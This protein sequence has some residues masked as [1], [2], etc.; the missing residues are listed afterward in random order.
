LEKQHYGDN[1]RIAKYLASQNIGSRREIEKFIQQKRIKVNGT[2]INSPITFVSDQDNI[3][4][5]NRLVEPQDKI[6]ILKFHKPIKYITSHKRQNNK[7]IIF[8]IIDSKYRNYKTAGRLDYFSEG[9]LILS[10]DGEVSRNLELPKNKFKRVYEVTISGLLNEK[11]LASISKGGI[12]QNQKYKPFSY[13]II[14]EQKKT[15]TLKLTLKEGKNREIRN[16]M[17]YLKLNISKLKRIEYGPFKLNSLKSKA[18]EVAN[19]K[20]IEQYYS[21]IKK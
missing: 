5:D 13:Q 15:T 19:E 6:T 17:S 14:Y 1:L 12:I 11:N 4:F 20:E 3:Q 16:I 2:T 7:P 9:L 18:L 21:H 8:D 10:S